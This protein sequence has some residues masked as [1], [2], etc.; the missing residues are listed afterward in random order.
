MSSPTVSTSEEH[1]IVFEGNGRNDLL[2]PHLTRPVSF[3]GLVG[4]LKEEEEEEGKEE[5]EE[6]EEEEESRVHVSN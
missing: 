4:E 5:E 3:T 2:P 1:H 6:E